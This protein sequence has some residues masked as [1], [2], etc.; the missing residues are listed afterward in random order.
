MRLS[1]CLPHHLV[2]SA[3]HQNLWEWPYLIIHIVDKADN[4][5]RGP[6]GLELVLDELREPATSERA[7]SAVRQRTEAPNV[8]Q[9]VVYLRTSGVGTELLSFRH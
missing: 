7:T 8:A 1:L 4:T 9:S 2:G 3:L 6:A 5:L